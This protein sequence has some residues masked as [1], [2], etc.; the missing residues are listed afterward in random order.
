MAYICLCLENGW[1]NIDIE[2]CPPTAMWNSLDIVGM[3][4]F[5]VGLHLFP[6]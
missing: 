6:G 4:I 1:L 3:E 5:D 2:W